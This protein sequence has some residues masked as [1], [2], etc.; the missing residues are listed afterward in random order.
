MNYTR[1]VGLG[2]ALRRAAFSPKPRMFDYIQ[3]VQHDAD[4]HFSPKH[5]GPSF[6]YSQTVQ[7]LPILDSSHSNSFSQHCPDTISQTGGWHG[8]PEHPASRT[9]VQPTLYH[10][11]ATAYLDRLHRQP[12][13]RRWALRPCAP[14]PSRPFRAPCRPL[15]TRPS[16]LRFL[17]RVSRRPFHFQQREHHRVCRWPAG[18]GQGRRKDDPGCAVRI[19]LAQRVAPPRVGHREMSVISCAPSSCNRKILKIDSSPF[20][21][22]GIP[23]GLRRPWCHGHFY[24][25]ACAVVEVGSYYLCRD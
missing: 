17:S 7:Y 9:P 6:R 2:S 23:Y 25:G 10:L 18:V 16:A 15:T 14:S 4:N 12:R 22:G 19:P 21:Q 24:G 3:L 20:A 11:P 8:H 1:V 13:H 5:P